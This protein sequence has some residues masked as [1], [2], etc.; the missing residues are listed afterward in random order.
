MDFDLIQFAQEH[1]YR[2]RNLVDGAPCPPTRRQREP[3]E[4]TA[5]TGR[6][7]RDLAIIGAY[8][9]IA[10]GA[11]AGM[12]GFCI[13]RRNRR[14]LLSTLRALVALGAVVTQEGDI[15]A[16]G[17]LPVTRIVEALAIM[18]VYRRRIA[19][20]GAGDT[21]SQSTLRGGEVFPPHLDQTARR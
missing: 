3:G 19:P 11:P 20:V 7:D 2:V 15:E 12:V 14:G 6:E 17:H 16:G 1:G 18:K 5:Y 21:G 8:G 4:R 9:F 10:L 13:F